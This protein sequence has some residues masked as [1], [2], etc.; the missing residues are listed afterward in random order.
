VRGNERINRAMR[1]WEMRNGFPYKRSEFAHACDAVT[2]PI[3][4]FFGRPK[5]RAIKKGDYRGLARNSRRHELS[6]I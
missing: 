2:Y 1:C 4:R 5:V 3:Y 6:H